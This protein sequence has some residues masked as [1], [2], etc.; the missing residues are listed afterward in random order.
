MYYVR[1]K[2][3]TV[4]GGCARCVCVSLQHEFLE[5]LMRWF[6]YRYIMYYCHCKLL[7]LGKI[8][9]TSSIENCRFDFFI[10]DVADAI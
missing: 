6:F 10:V 1:C 3:S 4:I 9:R 8:V 2:S 7:A 5:L